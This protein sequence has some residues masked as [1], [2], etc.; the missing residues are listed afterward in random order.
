MAKKKANLTVIYHGQRRRGMSGVS[1]KSKIGTAHYPR[2][3]FR[4]FND[5]EEW[6]ESAYNTKEIYDITY[7]GRGLH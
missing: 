3:T 4:R 2:L 1:V 6:A 7:R 5:L